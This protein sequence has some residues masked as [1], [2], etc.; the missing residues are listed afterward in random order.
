M[1]I[2]KTTFLLFLLLLLVSI[3]GKTFENFLLISQ[4]LS[5]LPEQ[6]EEDFDSQYRL[7]NFD[8]SAI[9]VNFIGNNENIELK[10]YRPN[11]FRYLRKLNSMS[12]ES[13]F[14]NQISGWC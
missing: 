3:S 2:F 12:T 5:Q 4:G 8:S 6:M 10:V 13:E 1:V 9:H 11:S 7:P 14:I